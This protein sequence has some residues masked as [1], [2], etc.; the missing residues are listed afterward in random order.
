LR[1][2]FVQQQIFQEKRFAGFALPLSSCTQIHN[3]PAHI[4]HRL[5][6]KAP[7]S[8][9]RKEDKES[10]KGYDTSVINV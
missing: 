2:F 10:R 4:R 9:I 1:S 3:K 8:A 6:G 7:A 5:T